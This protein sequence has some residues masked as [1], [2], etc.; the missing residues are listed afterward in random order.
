MVNTVTDA[1]NA[2]LVTA[3]STSNAPGLGFQ[4]QVVNF[5]LGALNNTFN[6]AATTLPGGVVYTGLPGQMKAMRTNDDNTILY[7]IE[8]DGSVGDFTYGSVG[9]YLADG[10]L[11]T[12][13]SLPEVRSKISNNNLPEAVGNIHCYHIPV[14]ITRSNLIFD[15]TL[16]EM[17]YM[18]LPR[19]AQT[20]DLPDPGS[21]PY[22]AYIVTSGV[23]NTPA[24]AFSQGTHWTQVYNNDEL[25]GT[26]IANLLAELTAE[27]LRALAQN[28]IDA[29]VRQT[30]SNIPV[31]SGVAYIDATRTVKI[32]P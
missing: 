15:L 17:T 24:L 25:S 3:L 10:T 18:S 4:L 28:I 20:A 14:T 19:V 6:P 13:E 12:Y 31:A 16:P 5:K 2:A 9:L 30:G 8:L 26:W 21:A 1:G 32:A 27:Q 29:L 22:S 11:L 23:A 7:Y